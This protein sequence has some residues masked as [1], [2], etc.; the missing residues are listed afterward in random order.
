MGF[1][2]E[3]RDVDTTARTKVIVASMADHWMNISRDRDGVAWKGLVFA[4][5]YS[6]K[7]RCGATMP[8]G[9]NVLYIQNPS[10]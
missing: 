5:H 1:V 2:S 8:R 9:L 6:R 10:F 4:A 7:K 3:L